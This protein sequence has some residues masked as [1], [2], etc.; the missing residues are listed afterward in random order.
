MIK[1]IILFFITA[2][3]KL[4]ISY[5]PELSNLYPDNI[6]PSVTANLRKFPIYTQGSVGFLPNDTN[7][8]DKSSWPQFSNCTVFAIMNITCDYSTVVDIAEERGA[9]G[10]IFVLNLTNSRLK[11]VL[12][13][14]GIQ[15]TIFVA[16]ISNEYI[17]IWRKFKQGTI[18]VEFDHDWIFQEKP[19]I[20]Y[21]LRK[22]IIMMQILLRN[23][24]CIYFLFIKMMCI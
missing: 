8:C 20:W 16:G 22:I 3:C 2:F 21:H 9:Q 7:P 10:V 17:D 15:T 12:I 23:D 19:R 13:S 6:V 11:E 4:R 18:L 14:T 5:P 24:I 1:I